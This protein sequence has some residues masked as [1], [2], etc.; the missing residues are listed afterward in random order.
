MKKIIA[1]LSALFFSA[2][3]VTGCAS[4]KLALK[5]NSPLAIVT[6]VGNQIVTWNTGEEDQDAGTNLI[7]SSINKMMDGNNPEILTAV[8]RLDFIDDSLRRYLPELAGCAVVDK[9]TV[10]GSEVYQNT[11]KSMYNALI[12]TKDATDYKDF[13]TLGAKNARLFMN[14]FNAK[15]LL[16]VNANFYKKLAKGNKSSG[17]VD[18]YV[19][20]RFKLMDSRGREV[21]SRTYSALGDKSLTISGGSYDKK[22]FVEILNTASENAI[23]QFCL[24]YMGDFTIGDTSVESSAPETEVKGTP[25]KINRPASSGTDKQNDENVSAS[26]ADKEKAVENA[27]KLLALDIMTVEQISE[28]TG[29]SVE[30]VKALKE[31]N[32]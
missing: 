15:S 32:K 31:E 7:S 4:T 26:S 14:E 30:E 9:K 24:A 1:L 23:K 21:V 8:D 2:I 3:F 10:V 13:T 19:E 16:I 18:A 6:I 17:L 27:K 22:A 11:R 5:D 29:L 28:V 12:S 20:L 25:I